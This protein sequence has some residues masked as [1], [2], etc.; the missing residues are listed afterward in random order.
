MHPYF[1]DP[2]IIQDFNREEYQNSFYRT[3]LKLE[4]TQRIKEKYILNR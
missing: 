4:Y 3:S 2:K 1:F